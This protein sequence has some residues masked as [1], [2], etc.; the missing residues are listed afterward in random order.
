MER[1]IAVRPDLTLDDAA[2]AATLEVVR[3]L[4]GLPLALELAAARASHLSIGEIAT[5]L[6]ERFELLTGGRRRARARQLTLRATMDWSYDLLT[7][8]EQSLLRACSVFLGG[9]TLD[10]LV[11]VADSPRPVVLDLLGSLV[12]KSLVLADQVDGATTRY[13]LLETVRLYGQEQLV[14]AGEGTDRRQ[15]HARF[16]ANSVR[17]ARDRA[18]ATWRIAS[19]DN[20]PEPF[21]ERDNVIVALEWCDDHDDLAD[22]GVLASAIAILTSQYDWSDGAWRYLGREDILGALSETDRAFY[23]YASAENANGIGD[24][25]SQRAFCERALPLVDQ[26]P[27][28]ALIMCSQSVAVSTIDA[29]T[30]EQIVNDVLAFVPAESAIANEALQLKAGAVTMRGDLA[31]AIELRERGRLS[32]FSAYRARARAAP[33]G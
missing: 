24:F 11:D 10:A 18:A 7:A 3:Q 21:D 12:R 30:A 9:F 19:G 13:H 27:L 15:R 6:D 16:F 8:A 31:A 20:D 25:A 4:D 33:P 1:A 29:D 5:F 14:A 28:R 17:T 32:G 2:R 26:G 23:L 22:V